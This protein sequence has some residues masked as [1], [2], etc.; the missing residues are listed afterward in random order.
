MG[1]KFLQDSL[2]TVAFLKP[3]TKSTFCYYRKVG[4]LLFSLLKIL[5]NF[6]SDITDGGDFYGSVFRTES[7]ISSKI[8]LFVKIANRWAKSFFLDVG[9]G[10]ECTSTL[11]T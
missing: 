3:S 4:S 6:N 10:S 8:E 7:N 2:Y 5:K 1:K 9:L 11:Y